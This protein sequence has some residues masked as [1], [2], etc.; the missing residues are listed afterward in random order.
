MEL[1]RRGWLEQITLRRDEAYQGAYR[2]QFLAVSHRWELNDKPDSRGV[3]LREIQRYLRENPSTRWVWY[4]YSCVWRDGGGGDRM[5]DEQREDARAQLLNC[6]IIFLGASVLLVMDIS[7]LSR[8]WTQL[9][10]WLSM[11]QPTAEGVRTATAAEERFTVA[12]VHSATVGAED[13]KLKAMWARRTP[14]DAYQILS[15]PDVVVTNLSDKTAMLAQVESLNSDLERYLTALKWFELQPAGESFRMVLHPMATQLFDQLAGPT[16]V[17]AV[18]GKVRTGKSYLMNAL[19]EAPDLFVV[20]SGARSFTRGVHVSSRTTTR[21]AATGGD[22][23][24]TFAD[25]EGQGDQ[26]T[27]YDLKLVSPLLLVTKVLILNVQC[28]TGPVREEILESLASVMHAARQ[29]HATKR[30]P[31]KCYGNLHVVLRDCAHAEDE[32]YDIIFGMERRNDQN[33]ELTNRNEVR[34]QVRDAFESEP[35]VWCLPKVEA[36]KAGL[37][38]NYRSNVPSYVAKIDELRSAV[39]A[40]ACVPKSLDGRLLTGPDIASTIKE[41]VDADEEAKRELREL[42]VA[43]KHDADEEAMTFQCVDAQYVLNYLGSTLPR[44]QELAIQKVLRPLK[45]TK[46]DAYNAAHAETVLVVSHR[47]ESRSVADLSGEQ[48][49]AIQEYLR[50][51]KNIK[52]VWYDSWSVPQGKDKTPAEHYL[53]R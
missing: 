24:L 17:V 18:F 50:N 4:D 2:D 42:E 32:C 47:W 5:T 10:A 51:H 30:E 23:H 25:I 34:Q 3:Q 43:M 48:L 38:A 7:Y 33:I 14:T 16:N 27:L 35:R 22:I 41:A 31:L 45:V 26:G 29:L 37:P 8:F 20:S 21:R 40:Q 36:S 12:L 6:P 1:S 11:Q 39:A 19:A 15:A 49:K 44:F 53:F 13:E 46:G 28:S 52:L 9:E